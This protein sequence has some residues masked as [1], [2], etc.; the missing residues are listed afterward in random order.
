MEHF[1]LTGPAAEADGALTARETAVLGLIGRGLRNV[2]VAE[3]LGLSE[4][5]V[6]THIKAIYRK[7]GISSRAEASW[8]AT[9][10]GLGDGSRPRGSEQ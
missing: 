7:L 1:R 9:R 2:D 10:M 4:N 5:T 3:S 8:H 6:A